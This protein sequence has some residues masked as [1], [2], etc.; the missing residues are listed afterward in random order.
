MHCTKAHIWRVDECIHCK[1]Q[2]I[3]A[4]IERYEEALKYYAYD[5]NSMTDDRTV[6]RK[7]LE[8]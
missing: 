1:I 7:A 5:A 2:E 8:D 4:K 6:A 3:D